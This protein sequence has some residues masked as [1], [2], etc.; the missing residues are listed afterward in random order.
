V[1]I[2]FP[3]VGPAGQRRNDKDRSPRKE[4][5]AAASVYGDAGVQLLSNVQ[6]LDFLVICRHR[7]FVG[8]CFPAVGPAGRGGMRRNET[9]RSN[10]KEAAAAASVCKCVQKLDI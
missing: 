9:D 2:F 10:S 6:L 3:A 4:A 7:R 1:G 5:A 8:T